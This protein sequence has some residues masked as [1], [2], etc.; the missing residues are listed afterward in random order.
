[1]T[2][3]LQR[4][5][6]GLFGL[7]HD[8]RGATAAIMA[9]SI[10]ALIGIAGVGVETGLWF[11]EKRDYQTA[12]DAAAVSGAFL[13]SAADP[14]L[15]GTATANTPC[16][17][18]TTSGVTKC[19]SAIQAYG[20]TIATTPNNGYVS[21][22]GNTITI[23][24]GCASGSGS[25]FTFAAN[26]LPCSGTANP[27]VKAVISEPKNT[28]FASL[29]IGGVS[30]RSSV[31]I[32]ASA[33]ALVLFNAN[34]SPCDLALSK[35]GTGIGFQGNATLNQTTCS[36]AA[37]S[38]DGCAI[39][40]NGNPTVNVTDIYS[41]GGYCM[42][43]NTTLNTG[44][45]VPVTSGSPIPD[46]Y[47]SEMGNCSN[48]SSFT[49]PSTPA[50]TTAPTGTNWSPGH[51]GDIKITGSATFASGTY[52]IDSACKG[53]QGTI[54]ISGS[55]TVTGTGV[56]FIY[57]GTKGGDDL[58]INSSASVSLSAPTSSSTAT[59][60]P[61]ILFY[62][63][64][65]ASA[66]I[67]GGSALNLQGAI[68]LPNAPITYNGSSATQT[69]N[70]LVIVTSTMTFEGTTDLTNSGCTGDGVNLITITSIALGQ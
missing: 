66:K 62:S 65:S 25:T 27:A 37:N 35:T 56:T 58:S 17:K 15:V 2:A 24:A 34:G 64:S 22:G 8:A 46:P 18:S 33:V 52:Y 5:T 30:G 63:P 49:M 29:N 10:A 31:T 32:N 13:L 36:M 47:C 4:F 9:V 44:T 14:S 16:F 45:N 38:S 53:G 20:T 11:S 50:C 61:G 54:A 23:N 41:V 55:S 69:T 59:P 19:L 68:Y 12:A 67:N 28:T 48:T 57:N 39:N 60:Y 40:G 1:M 7:I 43:S 51:Y 3:I 70:C 42:G 26:G 21:G 6:Y